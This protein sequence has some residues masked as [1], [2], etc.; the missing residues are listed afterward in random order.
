MDKEL[1]IMPAALRLLAAQITAPD[2]VPAMCLRDAAAMI[3]SLSIERTKYAELERENARLRECLEYTVK[4]DA[5]LHPEHRHV[6][7]REL[8][9]LPNVQDQR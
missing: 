2:H 6:R 7:A 3:E 9:G 8:L 5:F 1:K 4:T